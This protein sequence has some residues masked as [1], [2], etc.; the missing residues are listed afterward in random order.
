MVPGVFVP[1]AVLPIS[2]NGK[3]DRKALPTDLTRP[4][5]SHEYV[6]PR[7][8]AEERLAAVWADVLHVERQSACATISSIG[9]HSLVATQ[10]LSRVRAE[11]GVELPL[12][13]LFEAP[14]LG[15]FAAAVAAAEQAK[16]GPALARA[17]GAEVPM[18]FGQKRLWFLD[19]LEPGNPAYHLSVA[20]RLVG[21]LDRPV[22]Q[23]CMDAIFARHNALRTSFPVTDGTPK[24][25]V[26]PP[27]S[28]EI[29]ITDIS[30]LPPADREPRVRA[31]APRALPSAVRFGQWPALSCPPAP[32][33]RPRA[34][35]P[36]RCTISSPTAGRLAC[37]CGSWANLLPWH[38]RPARVASRHCQC[39]MPISP[40][41]NGSG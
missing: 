6:A 8:A 4:D 21:S 20:V 31:L 15:D 41:G 18:S 23:W 22:L 26:A 16:L 25:A 38:V 9:G 24:A 35:R 12:R 30:G 13:K 36:S 1:L 34:R 39:N 37:S 2:P 14:V 33:F 40:A 11:F 32:H 5:V 17:E 3:V 10:L 29:P 28:V 27:T 7:S 19:R